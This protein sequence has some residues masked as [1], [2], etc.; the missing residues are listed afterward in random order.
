MDLESSGLF[1]RSLVVDDVGCLS[2]FSS[3]YM[4]ISLFSLCYAL[5]SFFFL[6]PF[7]SVSYFFSSNFPLSLSLCQYIF[8]SFTLPHFLPLLHPPPP[9]SAYV[10]LTCVCLYFYLSLV[11]CNHQHSSLSLNETPF[12]PQNS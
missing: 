6:F 9:P 3:G 10:F 2:P 5:L 12:V 11:L 1:V 7:L 4:S 8:Y